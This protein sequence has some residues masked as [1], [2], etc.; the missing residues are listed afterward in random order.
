MIYKIADNRYKD[1]LASRYRRKRFL[2]FQAMI[3]KLDPPI[4]ILDVGGT[5]SYWISMGISYTEEYSVTLLNIHKPS[6]ISN[7]FH[8]II[9][10]ARKMQ[11]DR[12]S[13][14]VVYSNSVIEHIGG[15]EDQRRMADEIRRVGRRYFVQ[16]PNKLFPLEP[17]FHFPFFQFLPISVRTRLLMNFRLGWFDRTRD[18]NKSRQIVENIRLI[19]KNEICELFPDGYLFEEKFLLLTKSFIIFGG[20]GDK[21]Q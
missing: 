3:S 11:F 15:F 5:D 14:D 8:Y 2:L 18:I 21:D 20:W 12:E 4:S 10:D 17:H 13:F 9:G 6:T 19:S 7:N 1:S 16:T